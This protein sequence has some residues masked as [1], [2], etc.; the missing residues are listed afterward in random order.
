MLRTFSIPFPAEVSGGSFGG[1]AATGGEYPRAGTGEK[2]GPLAAAGGTNNTSTQQ[3]QC[4]TTIIYN[5]TIPRNGTLCKKV[6]L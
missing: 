3:Q 6:Y 2:I 1:R 5:G 4:D